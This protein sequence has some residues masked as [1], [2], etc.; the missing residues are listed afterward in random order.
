[1]SLELKVSNALESLVA[2]LGER[3]KSSTGNVFTPHYLVTQTEGM[4]IWLKQQLALQLGIVANIDF[5]KPND[6]IFKVYQLLGGVYKDTLSRES[7]I[8]FLYELMGQRDFMMRYPIQAAYFNVAGPEKDLKRMGLAEKMADIFDQ[9]QIYRPELIKDWNRLDEQTR[10]LDWQAFLWIKAKRLSSIELP[11]KTFVSDYI[12]DHLKDQDGAAILRKRLPAVYL[13]GLSIITRYHMDILSEIAKVIDVYFYLLN[14]APEI[15]WIDD[16]NEK[17]VAI[18]R[19]RGMPHTD[20]QLIGNNLLTSWGKVLQNTFRL[21]FKNEDLI[22]SYDT[23]GTV[24]P[25]PDSLLHKI[26]YD[27]FNNSTDGRLPLTA[28][29]IDDGSIAIHSNYTIANEVESLY[30]YLV[31]LVNYHKVEISPRDIVVMVSDIDTY[32]PYIKAVF[33]NSPYKF[34]FKIADT[35]LT[36][37]DNIYS[38][39]QQILK[40]NEQNFTSESVM[41]LLDSAYIRSRFRIIDVDRL[42]IIVHSAGIRFGMEGRKED[43]TDLVSW[44]YGLKRIMYGLC[45]SGGHEYTDGK[46][47][48]YPLDIAEGTEAWEIIRFCHFAEVLMSSVKSR[49]RE[50]SIGDWVK[51][52]EDVVHDLVFLPEDEANEDYAVLIEKLSK[53]NELNELMEESVAYEIFSYNIVAS[54]EAD[55]RSSLFINDGITFCSLIPMRSIPFRVVAMLGMDNDNFPR[56]EKIVNFNLIHKKHELGDRNI[57][58]ND[59][60]LFLE[61]ILSAKDYL[62]M[63]YVGKSVSDNTDKPAS[64]LVD[65][66]IDYI[67]SG[68]TE[69][70]SVRSKIVIQQPL[71]SFSRK[72]NSVDEKLYR[73]SDTETGKK[74][75]IFKTEESESVIDF[76]EIRF[77]DVIAFYKNS[78]KSFYNKT[79]GIYYG[80]EEVLL[81]ETEIFELGSLENWSLKNSLLRIIGAEELPGFRDE[82]VRKGELPLKNIGAAVSRKMYEEIKPVS[83]LVRQHTKGGEEETEM[84]LITL[85][86]NQIAGSVNRIYNGKL[87]Q[88]CWSSNTIKYMVEAYLNTLAGIACGFIREV[89]LINGKNESGIYHGNLAGIDKEEATKRLERIIAFYKKGLQYRIPF[90]EYF[91]KDIKDLDNLDDTRLRMLLE[92]KMNNNLF[93]F[94]DPYI[95]KEY[96]NG[97]FYQEGIARQFIEAANLVIAPVTRIFDQFDFYKT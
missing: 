28:A 11:D 96:A 19:Q 9:Y 72:Y 2:D 53:Y 50:R 44:I 78:L 15:Y 80:A 6:L 86:G 90:A 56:K 18:W 7:L 20:T 57:K 10:S 75:D 94:D 88:L 60:H 69:G 36:Q 84:F 42:R 81:S 92:K 40:L 39:L 87:V 58:D 33:D 64:I 59:K 16:K 62:F 83:D 85:D 63:S 1:M 4:N 73:Y 27:I 52:V 49:R 55:S 29:D 47:T 66:L 26:Q 71:H 45:M 37:G 91:Y 31:H 35:S 5:R 77:S 34:R 65:E 82:L 17:D 79:L 51:Y 21:L 67:A 48:L 25:Q 14:P 97:L 12:L 22:N 24:E 38:A 30:H 93:P 61:T 89:V 95:L 8:W 74:L 13:F 68:V 32:A 3:L 23:I 54:L 43:E 70:I 46:D 76:E 41:Q